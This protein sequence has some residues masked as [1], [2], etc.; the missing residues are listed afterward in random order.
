MENVLIVGVGSVLKGDDGVGMRVVEELGKEALGDGVKLYGGDISGLDLLKH[1]PESGRVIIID[2]ADM[3]EP[4]G[5]VKVFAFRDIKRSEFN[6]RFSTHSMGLLETLTLA[7]KIGLGC[8]VTIVGVQPENTDYSLD[9]S[10]RVKGKI[11]FIVEEV[12]RLIHLYR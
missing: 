5:T 9:L 6:D 11:P 4:A 10:D 2:A 8:D 12:K 3:G 7:E 1:F